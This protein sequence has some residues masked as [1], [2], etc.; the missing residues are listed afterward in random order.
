MDDNI[1]SELEHHIDR[2]SEETEK[3]IINRIKKLEKR[4]VKLFGEKDEITSS[5]DEDGGDGGD[6]GK[7][8]GNKK[9]QTM[10]DS[11]DVSGSI[12]NMDSN[13][14]EIV[15]RINKVEKDI[16]GLGNKLND[17][18]KVNNAILKRLEGGAQYSQIVKKKNII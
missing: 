11:D 4:L 13:I 8:N 6:D 7:V 17:L 16:N 3:N 1:I 14:F 12:K 9:T 2:N 10:T 5:D 15:G 18:I